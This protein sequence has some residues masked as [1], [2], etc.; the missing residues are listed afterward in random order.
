MFMR[1]SGSIFLLKIAMV[2]DAYYTTSR[3]PD[4]TGRA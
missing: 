2:A 3:E 4:K 1:S